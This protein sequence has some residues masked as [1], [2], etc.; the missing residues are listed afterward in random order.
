M[1]RLVLAALMLLTAHSA[2]ATSR[3]AAKA[4][5][6]DQI[7]SIIEEE[8][9]AIFRYP[10]PRKPSL[11]L[12]DRYVR[13]SSFCTNNQVVENVRI[14]SATAEQC[15]VK[16]CRTRPDDCEQRAETCF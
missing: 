10:S 14:P 5:T 3:Y 7:S 4:L 16:R 12:Y 15:P 9:V 6:C 1:S 13:D 11:T 2:G 8:G